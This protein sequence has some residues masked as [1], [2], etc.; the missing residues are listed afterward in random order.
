MNQINVTF[1]NKESNKYYIESYS[2][3][4]PGYVYKRLAEDLISKKLNQCTYI[5]SIRRQNLYNGYAEITVIYDNNV[6]AIY[7]I[8]S[9]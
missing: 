1:Y 2:N 9:R 4:E 3:S 5:K 7:T 6:K 8:E